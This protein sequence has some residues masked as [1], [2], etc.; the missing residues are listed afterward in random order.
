MRG[1][2]GMQEAM[3]TFSKLEDFVPSD[4]PLR[5]SGES[6]FEFVPQAKQTVATE[7]TWDLPKPLMAEFREL[8]VEMD[9]LLSPVQDSRMAVESSR[10]KTTDEAEPVMPFEERLRTLDRLFNQG[11]ITEEEYQLKRQKLLEKL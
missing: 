5:A 7:H 9:E 2:D 1:S 4:H 8:M 11:L 10:F 3:F 6:F